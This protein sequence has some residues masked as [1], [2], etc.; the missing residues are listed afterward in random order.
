M[1]I[2]P[3][4]KTLRTV[5]EFRE[6]LEK[7]KNKYSYTVLEWKYDV[8]RKHLWKILNIRGYKIPR[9]VRA[10]LGIVLPRA[11]C[12]RPPTIEIRID[13]PK[14]AARS[15]ASNVEYDVDELIKELRK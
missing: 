3:E 5:D 15:I 10:K 6:E 1:V 8:N 11:R 9:P 14:S 13:D 4:S 2:P 7:A 12:L